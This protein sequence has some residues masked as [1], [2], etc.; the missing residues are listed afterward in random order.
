MDWQVI[1][2]AG[3]VGVILKAIADIG[4]AWIRRSRKSNHTPD[5]TEQFTA[6]IQANQSYREEVRD[7]MDKMKKEFDN[8]QSKY[9]KDLHELTCKYEI[10]LESMKNKL[11]LL[12]KEVIEYRQENGALHLLLKQQ[13]VEV[14]GWIKKSSEK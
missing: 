6:L 4:V 1:I 12:T 7:D 14:P 11:A 13:G 2:P 10:E 9:E 3:V 5:L 8:L